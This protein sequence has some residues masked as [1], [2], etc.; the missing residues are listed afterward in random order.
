MI[1][2]LLDVS[3][4]QDAANSL[5]PVLSFEG[6]EKNRAIFHPFKK[7][8]VLV[9]NSLHFLKKLIQHASTK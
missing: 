2:R 3:A 8:L 1:F 4:G 5:I 9:V 6:Q 7:F